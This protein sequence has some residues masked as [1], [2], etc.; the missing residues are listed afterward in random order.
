L[1]TQDPNSTETPT[2]AGIP[3]GEPTETPT[4]TD[5][6]TQ[7]PISTETATPP[8]LPTG[9][10]TP[11]NTPTKTPTPAPTPQ[12]RVQVWLVDFGGSSYR[13]VIRDRQTPFNHELIANSSLFPPCA[14]DS[15]DT[16]WLDCAPN[17][18]DGTSEKNW[19]AA[20]IR[21]R[22]V[23]LN[24]VRFKI[25]ASPAL[26]NV[27]V[28]G[29]ASLT[30]TSVIT[31]QQAG[32][33][34]V[35]QEIVITNVTSIGR[36]PNFVTYFKP[37]AI[38]W[39]IKVATQTL[40]AGVSRH[41]VYVLWNA[42]SISSLYLTVVDFTTQQ[43]NGQSLEPGVVNGIWREFTDT[44][45]ARRELNPVAGT[46]EVS[47]TTLKYWMP[48]T[49][50]DA[51]RLID[52]ASY[53]VMPAGCGVGTAGLLR[54]A[55]AICGVWAQFMVD[56]LNTHG[57]TAQQ[58]TAGRLR[59]FPLGPARLDPRTSRPTN[60][61]A[62]TL[63]LINNWTITRSVCA[64]PTTGVVVITATRTLTRAQVGA[65]WNVAQIRQIGQSPEFSDLPGVPGQSNPNP[66]GWFQLGDHAL[67]QYGPNRVIYDPS[68]GTGP[69]PNIG[70]WAR[71]SL[72]G[73]AAFN[74]TPTRY[75]P[76][77]LTADT[78]V[79]ISACS[80]IPPA[81]PPAFGLFVP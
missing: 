16:E 75:S 52:G 71:A 29:T 50:T 80:G 40:S 10:P 70:A 64:T 32:V 45:V 81:G 43:A 77:Q 58:V 9:Q 38:D 22:N 59:G 49:I 54:E 31:F 76:D 66:P 19:P 51:L 69:F 74:E 26:T 62:A 72:A 67:V 42:P 11:T 79:T 35:G 46:I 24:Q 78:Q 17:W 2:P 44:V 23:V 28:I 21:D 5:I 48:W 1:P 53:S 55:R 47:T 20:Y 56:S 36:L 73:Y 4:P 30:G 39:K 15:G 18:P 63:M 7:E 34:Q 57:I 65:A 61:P 60:Q 8:N 37:L 33:N 27:T 68:Y 41:P 25:E 12:L 14:R 3:T 6:P 13:E